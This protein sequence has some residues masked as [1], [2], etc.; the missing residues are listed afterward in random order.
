MEQYLNT[1]LPIAVFVCVGI[2]FGFVAY[3]LA[4]LFRPK[5]IDSEDARTS[6]ECGIYPERDAKVKFNIRYLVFVLLF[7]AFDVEAIF[8]YP[9]AVQAR[10]LGEY[11]LVEVTIFILII[12]FGWAYAWGRGLLTWD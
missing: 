9:W 6:Y 2:G 10:F 12:L 1:Y 5:R 8:L 7:V 4:H 11:A 3:F